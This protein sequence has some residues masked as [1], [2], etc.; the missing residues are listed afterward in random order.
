MITLDDLRT[1]LNA[2]PFEPFHLWLS[3]GGSVEVRSRELVMAGKRFALVGLLDAGD[4]W[5]LD[6]KS[7]QKRV[8]NSSLSAGR[9]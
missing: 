4:A 5:Q 7:C 6:R 1:L 2:Q 3:D 8:K 9:A